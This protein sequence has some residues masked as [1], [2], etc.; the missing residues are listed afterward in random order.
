MKYSQIAQIIPV[1]K[2]DNLIMLTRAQIIFQEKLKYFPYAY[3]L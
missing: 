2:N 1:L 3:F